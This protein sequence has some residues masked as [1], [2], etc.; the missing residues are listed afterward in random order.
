VTRR[1]Q[2]RTRHQRCNADA[3]VTG[4]GITAGIMGAPTRLHASS[5]KAHRNHHFDYRSHGVA[6]VVFYFVDVIGCFDHRGHHR[7]YVRPRRPAGWTTTGTPTH[8]GYVLEPMSV[9]RNICFNRRSI[10][11]RMKPHSSIHCV[12]T[13][14]RYTVSP[15]PL[16][17]TVI[18]RTFLRYCNVGGTSVSRRTRHPTSTVWAPSLPSTTR[19]PPTSS[20]RDAACITPASTSS[21]STTFD[22]RTT[23]AD[24]S[25]TSTST[26]STMMENRKR[27]V[28]FSDVE[29]QHHRQHH[30]RRHRLRNQPL[31]RPP[32]PVDRIPVE[33]TSTTPTT[34]VAWTIITQPTSVQ[35]VVLADS[36]GP[37]GT[38]LY[39]SHP[40]A[41][42]P[43]DSY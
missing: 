25:T 2:T 28:T 35:L 42:L 41:R 17:I 15:S 20:P 38:K 12:D 39:T 30:L 21:T 29:Q 11:R 40:R 26:L 19:Q 22:G 23:A 36:N 18:Y 1:Q 14:C 27:H 34:K 3:D 8:V 7:A 31:G 43:R 10:L 37:R 24:G 33:Y 32:S 16:N 6:A 9:R 4:V 13:L 5:T